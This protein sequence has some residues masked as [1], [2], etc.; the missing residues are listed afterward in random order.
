MAD[1]QTRNR[2]SVL[3]FFPSGNPVGGTKLIHEGD[4]IMTEIDKTRERTSPREWEKW[5]S[6]V[7]ASGLILYAMMQPS[8]LVNHQTGAIACVW[9][10]AVVFL[11]GY[12]VSDRNSYKK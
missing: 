10:S 4:T 5:V 6:L 11:Q 8:T 7:T 1:G 3:I 12:R 2:A 9:L